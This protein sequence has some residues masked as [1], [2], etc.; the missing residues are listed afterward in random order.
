[1]GADGGSVEIV[2]RGGEVWMKPDTE[3]WKAQVPG[4]QG[5]AVAE[6]FRD[7]YVHGSTKDT[8][9][10][11]LADTCDLSA[12]QK[13][14][15]DSPGSSSLTKGDETTVDGTK[16]I[17]L[18]GQAHHGKA[19]LYVTSDAPH[20][21]VSA[22]RKGDGTDMTLSFT[23]YDKPVPSRTPSPDD[24][25]DVGDLLNELRNT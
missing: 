25:V 1:M 3:F 22:T 10:K 12:F 17:P 5:D 23:D 4:S 24:S 2:K 6:L 15:D 18:K 16:V 13:N 19:T 8:L 20:R 11:G 9:L 7:R 14:V 21:L